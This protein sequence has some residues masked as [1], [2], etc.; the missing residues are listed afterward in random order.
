MAFRNGVDIWF[1]GQV[2]GNGNGFKLGG[3]NV[4]T[5]NTVKNCISF[6]NAGNTG[7][8]FDENNN[9]AG[10]TLY[11]CT[12]FRN[13]KA[14]YWFNNN[15][16]TI[17]THTIKNCI[18]YLPGEANSILNATQETNSW[19]G[20]TV[21][22]SDFLSVDTSGVTAPRDSTGR[23]LQSNFFRLAQ[24]SDLVNAGTNVGISYNGSAPD[25]GAYE[26]RWG[27]PMTLNLTALIEGMYNSSIMVSDTLTVE[28]RTATS[29]FTIVEFQKMVVN[30]SG[31]GTANFLNPIESELYYLVVKHRNALET[32]SGNGQSFSGGTLNYN[33]TTAAAQAFGNNMVQKG[34]K[35]C[36]YSGDVNQDAFIDGSDVAESFNAS[37][38]GLSGYEATDLNGDEFVDGSDVSIVHN[39]NNLGIGVS[40]PSKKNLQ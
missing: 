39:N 29:P 6:D 3:N 35:W 26:S 24:S 19:Q 12:S 33:F 8:G 28:L 1:T 27:I 25:L 31:V 21:S 13:K 23:L 10:Q 7:R 2:N 38:L 9:L 20:F 14:N 16:L 17:G 32:W 30:N 18:S 22:N 11:N 15:P 37:E 40:C 34:T 5:P 4:A 36:I